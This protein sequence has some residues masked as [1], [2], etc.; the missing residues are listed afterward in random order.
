MDRDLGSL[1]QGKLADLIVLDQDPLADLRNS[2][3]V[4]MTMVGGRL[5]DART[6]NEIGNRPRPARNSGSKPKV[7]KDGAQRRG[8]SSRTN[9]ECCRFSI[10]LA[11]AP[12]CADFRPSA[13]RPEFLMG[14]RG[15]L[16]ESNASAPSVVLF[17]M[18][19]A[20]LEKYLP[21]PRC[22]SC[23]KGIVRAVDVMT[24][25]VV[26]NCSNRPNCFFTVH[27]E[28][29]ALTKKIIYLDTSI[30]SKM[31][32]A[33]AREEKEYLDFRLYEALRR[34]T[35]RNLIVCPGST[36]VETEA[37]F[38]ALSD[39]IID[40]SRQLSDPG[41]H[42]E[43]YVKEA[44]LFRSLEQ[45]LTG[46][47][48]E[49]ELAPPWSDAFHSDP[50]K[51]HSMF[52]VI[53]NIR[54]PANF[55]ASGRAAKTATLAQIENLYREYER[56]G[57]TF[58]Q[59]LEVEE[60]AF[61]E[62]VRIIGRNMIAARLAHVRGEMDNAFVWLS[63]TF[64]KIAMMIQHRTS[65]SSDDSL[66]RAIDFLRSSHAWTTPYSYI[67]GRLS[68]QLAML[69]RGDR[70][71][72]PD[73]GDHYDIEH[74]ATFVPYVDVFIGDKF[75]AGIANQNNLRVGDPWG[76]EIRSLVP[77]EVPDFIDWLESLADGS[78]VAKRSESISES[79]WQGGFHQNFVKH[80]KATMPE[81]FTGEP[82]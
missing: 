82:E 57:F 78:E 77:K 11:N 39:T 15:G 56:D 71:R 74:M 72:R 3:S 16:D 51:W 2:E 45:W 64:D 20:T 17:A 73:D 80:I 42:H 36:V 52:N 60:R 1:E 29:P 43:L 40:M 8:R 12:N 79:I 24:G 50:D 6:M 37:E 18:A 47:P 69:C 13:E 46:L 75:F 28:L 32:K 48:P 5:Y 19:I 68:A 70:P 49:M 31:A 33:K 53:V 81:A 58:K 4:A 27:V 7:T 22:E 41:L 21:R 38:S 10:E 25:N 61:S 54:T 23:G 63:S 35:A 65:C 62:A 67:L 14:P 34:A 26:F 59:I 9:L 66:R 55:I 30:V 44:Q 76:T